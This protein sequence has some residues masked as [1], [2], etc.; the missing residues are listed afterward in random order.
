MITLKREETER[1]LKDF[2]PFKRSVYLKVSEIP[3][4]QTRS[5]KWVAEEVGA[6]NKIRAVAGIISKN[7]YPFFIPCHRV[8]RSNGAFG[9]YIFG[10]EF[11]KRL[12]NLEK[13]IK[14]IIIR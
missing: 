8:I 1:L 11:K 12:L 13:E 3:I 5:Y 14:S 2:T 4:G 6:P 7:P 10:S 9:G